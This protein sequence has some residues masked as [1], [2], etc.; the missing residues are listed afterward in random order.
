MFRPAPPPRH[1]TVYTHRTTTNY[2]FS[3]DTSGLKALAGPLWLMALTPLLGGLFTAIGN[4]AAKPQAGDTVEFITKGTTTRVSYSTMSKSELKAELDKLAEMKGTLNSKGWTSLDDIENE[5]AKLESTINGIN[6][7]TSTLN[8]NNLEDAEGN[9]LHVEDIISGGS[10]SGTAKEILES[11]FEN[12]KPIQKGML[13]GVVKLLDDL[14][15]TTAVNYIKGLPDF[16]QYQD[17]MDKCNKKLEEAKKELNEL[18]ELKTTLTDLGGIEGLDNE[19]ATIED[20]IANI[21]NYERAQR[22]LEK[23]QDYAIKQRDRKVARQIRRAIKQ[24]DYVKADRLA[25]QHGVV[26][27]THTGGWY[28]LSG[29]PSPVRPSGPSLLGP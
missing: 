7:T 11:K 22:N 2:D 4:A 27:G 14:G 29:T 5:I 1:T 25:Q 8:K 26:K 21:N 23:S 9:E 10:I 24:G 12:G 6:S 20:Q 17:T 19:I 13:Q 3:T 15:E 18:I 28:E 16:K